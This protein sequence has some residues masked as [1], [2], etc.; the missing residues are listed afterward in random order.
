MGFNRTLCKKR[1]P[2]TVV[3]KVEEFVPFAHW[4]RGKLISSRGEVFCRTGRG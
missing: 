4:N 2:D 1:W 3:V